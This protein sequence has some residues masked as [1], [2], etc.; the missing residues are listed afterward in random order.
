MR[1]AVIALDEILPDS[2]SVVTDV[3]RFMQAPWKYLHVGG[4]GRFHHTI[5]FGSIGLGLA[6]CNRSRSWW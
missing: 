3:G 1:S 5:N 4:Q 2:R 6:Y